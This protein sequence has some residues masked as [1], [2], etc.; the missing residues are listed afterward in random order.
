[1]CG[2][3]SPTVRLQNGQKADFKKAAI[4]RKGQNLAGHILVDRV[5]VP[6]WRDADETRQR[7][8]DLGDEVNVIRIQ[9]IGKV[10]SRVK[11]MLTELARVNLVAQSVNLFSIVGISEGQSNARSWRRGGRHQPRRVAGLFHGPEPRPRPA[12]PLIDLNGRSIE[13]TKRAYFCS[14]KCWSSPFWQRFAPCVVASSRRWSLV[15]SPPRLT[16]G[17]QRW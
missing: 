11:L 8:I 3:L 15:A 2:H 14:H 6:R 16:G 4:D 12:R 5:A 17:C 1:E 13:K 10:S 9:G 7:S